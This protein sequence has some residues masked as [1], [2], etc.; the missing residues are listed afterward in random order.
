MSHFPS[1]RD[2]AAQEGVGGGPDPLL[3]LASLF[4]GGPHGRLLFRW[5]G[6]VDGGQDALGAVE[7][8]LEACPLGGPGAA[9]RADE[10]GGAG[11]GVCPDGPVAGVVGGLRAAGRVAHSRPAACLAAG[12]PASFR[13]SARDGSVNQ[14]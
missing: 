11:D 8:G 2:V 10:R 5:R 6:G 9:E 4:S 1:G 12:V 14:Q 3:G 7:F 13:Q